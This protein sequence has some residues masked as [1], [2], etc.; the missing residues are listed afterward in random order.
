MTISIRTVSR[1]AQLDVLTTAI[2]NA[3]LL[4]I[5]DGTPPASANASLSSNNLLAECTCGSPFAGA[6]SSGVLTANAITSDSSANATGTA[7]FYRVY[8][9]GGTNCILQGSV[10][11]SG[12]DLNMNTVSIVTGGPVAITSWAL[13]AGNP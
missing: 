8:D 6:A 10:G 11:T 4:R 9:S 12:A 7:S 1:S 3:A 5:Y 13:T 2:G